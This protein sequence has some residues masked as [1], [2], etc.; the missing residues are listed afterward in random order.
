[1]KPVSEETKQKQAEA[2]RKYWDAKRQLKSIQPSKGDS[3]MFQK[4]TKPT[5]EQWAQMKETVAR[6][7]M[8]PAVIVAE[9][10][11]SHHVD[12]NRVRIDT[13]REEYEKLFG[14]NQQE[15]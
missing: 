15:V 6:F 5:F 11:K 3:I 12:L 2:R 8:N 4:K 10:Q 1:M 9:F 14:E 13:M 7:P